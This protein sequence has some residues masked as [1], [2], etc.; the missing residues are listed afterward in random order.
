MNTNTN[1]E[2]NSEELFSML[3]VPWHITKEEMWDDLAANMKT[4]KVIQF[5]SKSFPWKIGIAA[6]LVVSL[7]LG[8]FM[9]TYTTSINTVSAQHATT[10]LP[11]GSNIHLNAESEISYH[12]YWWWANRKVK[13]NGEA[14]FQVEKGKTFSV[15]ST[16]GAIEVLGTTFNVYSRGEN[17]EVACIS[18]KVKVKANTS[19]HS[20]ILHPSEKAILQETGQLILDETV[21]VEN[22]TAWISNKLVFTSIS[23]KEVFEE[24]ERQYSVEINVSSE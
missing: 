14:F 7:S 9:R 16:A 3:R 11:D 24:I 17:Y 15:I 10:K 4:H 22:T 18:G 21:N 19:K 20:V 6:V 2:P 1:T 23:L 8:I 13:M 12:P 5:K